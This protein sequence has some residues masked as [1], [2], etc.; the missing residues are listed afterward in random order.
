LQLTGA[1]LR[2]AWNVQFG[3]PGLIARS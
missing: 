1:R 3:T 2:R